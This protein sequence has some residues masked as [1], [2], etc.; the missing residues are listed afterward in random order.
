MGIDNTS[1]KALSGLFSAALTLALI[2]CASTEPSDQAGNAPAASQP[3]SESDAMHFS[4]TPPSGKTLF[5]MGQDI[6]TLHE[7]VA[8]T[9]VEPAAV[10]AY[11]SADL[12]GVFHRFPESHGSLDLPSYVQDYPDATLAIGLWMKSTYVRIANEEPGAIKNVERLIDNLKTLERPV[13]LRI[14]YEADGYWNGYAPEKYREA[15]Q[16]ISR[17]IQEKQAYNV[18]RVW[19][20]AAYC[21]AM[22]G[23][24]G[25][26][27]ERSNT[28]FGEDYDAWYPGDE[29]VDWVAFSYFSQPRDCLTETTQ[30]AAGGLPEGFGQLSD[31]DAEGNSLAID[32]V[33]DYLASKNK[34][35]FVA[36][37][38][39]KYYWIEK[40]EYKPDANSHI[41]NLQAVSAEDIW[42]GWYEPF[43]AFLERHQESIRAVSYI[44]MHWDAWTGW[45]CDLR[46]Q[47]AVRLGQTCQDGVWG[48]ARVQASELIQQRFF[49]RL[50]NGR[51]IYRLDKGNFAQLKDWDKVQELN[52]IK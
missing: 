46:N 22:D 40:G 48:D 42:Q 1:R 28:Y 35:I 26:F 30:K 11:A 36:E 45:R 8:D 15:F 24:H 6:D 13:L 4:F 18:S 25:S 20:I 29:H 49:E 23:S 43:F 17:I 37:A 47:E 7:F 14:G 44:N 3:S 12:T 41:E 31:V 32:N 19:Q 27:Q 52:Q 33:I 50:D 21:A 9:G 34:P 2:S 39:P 16:V 51:Y 10:T 38:S 5:F